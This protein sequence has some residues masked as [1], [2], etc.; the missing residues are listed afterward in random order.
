MKKIIIFLSL[1]I[2]LQTSFAQHNQAVFSKL[3]TV[4]QKNPQSSTAL[5]YV[6]QY[7]FFNQNFTDALLQVDKALIID[8]QNAE[9]LFFKGL[10]H[11]AQGEYEAALNSYDKT[12]AIEASTEFQLRRAMLRY[13]LKKYVG[14]WQDFKAILSEYEDMRSLD[15]YVKDCEKNGA[16]EEK[17]IEDNS[18]KTKIAPEN[19]KTFIESFIQSYESF[20]D[21]GEIYRA[22]L[23]FHT[24]NFEAVKPIFEKLIGKYNAHK[25]LFFSAIIHEIEEDNINASFL[26][27]KATK[28]VKGL[29]LDAQFEQLTGF[30]GAAAITSRLKNVQIDYE[31]KLK[32]LNKENI[33]QLKS[34]QD[35]DADLK[36]EINSEKQ[37][38]LY[39]FEQP[40]VAGNRTV[41]Q[42]IIQKKM[43]KKVMVARAIVEQ[44]TKD[45]W[46]VIINHGGLKGEGGLTWSVYPQD[47]LQATF[48]MDKNPV[49]KAEGERMKTLRNKKLD[50][51]TLSTL[52]PVN[53]TAYDAL[54]FAARVY[55]VGFIVK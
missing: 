3:E 15:K 9:L 48:T 29:L 35:T 8:A 54:T 11:E 10:N 39:S 26:Y 18:V 53:F 7:F 47:F 37:A 50:F 25:M 17:S 24:G 33:S 14:A 42:L 41:Y 4:S 13:K 19:P 6:G 28:N 21:S 34:I 44:P 40:E 31:N 12:I 43:G 51:K 5:F 30:P 22:F 16:S 45:K 36:G 32:E 49:Y 38:Y 1:F 2:A 20:G 52:K 27:Q 46:V 23:Y 55:M